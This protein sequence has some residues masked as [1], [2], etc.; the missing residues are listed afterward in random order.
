MD[1]LSDSVGQSDEIQRNLTKSDQIRSQGSGSDSETRNPIKSYK[2]LSDFVKFLWIPMDSIWDP[3]GFV[4][5]FIHLGFSKTIKKIQ[6]N[7]KVYETTF[8]YVTLTE[9][10]V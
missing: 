10:V 2:I 5:G 4:V 9:R 7:P 8:I 6:N 1:F 3:T